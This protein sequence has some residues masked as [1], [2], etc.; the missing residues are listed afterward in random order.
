MDRARYDRSGV[1]AMTRD[2]ALRQA[3]HYANA[4]QAIAMIWHTEFEAN[5]WSWSA[6]PVSDLDNDA[7]D[8]RFVL[9]NGEV[10]RL[11]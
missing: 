9:P 11:S 6:Y 1:V 5:E 2:L 8:I 10:T 4:E 7:I 3:M